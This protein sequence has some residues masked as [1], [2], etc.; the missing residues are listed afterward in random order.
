ME[1][2][3]TDRKEIAQAM[4]FGKYPVL[5]INM[6]TPKEGWELEGGVFKGCKVRIDTGKAYYDN[7]TLHYFSDTKNFELCMYGA[8]LTASFGYDDVIEMRDYAMAPIVHKGETVVVIEDYPI[9]K[10]CRV[11]LMKVPEF[12]NTLSSGATL[13]ELD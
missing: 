8:C 7:A 12:I 2:L 1:K 13:K 9:S 4:N 5:T 10:Q 11:H 3:L 6:E